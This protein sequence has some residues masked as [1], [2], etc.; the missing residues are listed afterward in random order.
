MNNFG[1]GNAETIYIMFRIAF[2]PW[3]R[4]TIEDGG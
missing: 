4:G 2:S 3:R 1:V